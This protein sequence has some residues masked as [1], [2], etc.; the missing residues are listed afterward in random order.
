MMFL[1]IFNVVNNYL[2]LLSLSTPSGLFVF[3]ISIRG[4]NPRLLRFSHYIAHWT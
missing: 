2:F 3:D 4:I 1:L